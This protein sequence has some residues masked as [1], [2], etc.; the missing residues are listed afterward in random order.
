MNELESQL[1]RLPS[2]QSVFFVV[3]LLV[4]AGVPF[5]VFGLSDSRFWFARWLGGVF[6]V[7]GIVYFLVHRKA[8]KIVRGAGV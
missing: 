1:R 8:L 5:F 4:L 2:K 6:V 3:A 7:L